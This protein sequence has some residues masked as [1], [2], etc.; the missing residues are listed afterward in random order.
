MANLIPLQPADPKASSD[1][2]TAPG[3]ALYAVIAAAEANYS[4]VQDYEVSVMKLSES[5]LQTSQKWSDYY[6]NIMDNQDEVA[7]KWDS[8][9]SNRYSY[10]G[11]SDL[12]DATTRSGVV[13]TDAST[14]QLHQTMFN[15]GNT[16]FSG[17]TNGEN[18]ASSDV[19]QTLSLNLQNI[20]SG[21]LSELTNLTSVL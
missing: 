5:L 2:F 1:T 21:P 11:K 10:D 15:Q 20:Q 17:L 13:N 4:S 7:L 16:Y 9:T 19:S 12:S 6:I 3:G 14:L 18:Q 8:S